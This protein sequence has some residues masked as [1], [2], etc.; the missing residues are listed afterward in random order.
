M[1]FIESYF[2]KKHITR[3]KCSNRGEGQKSAH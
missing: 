1:R 2:A 3:A